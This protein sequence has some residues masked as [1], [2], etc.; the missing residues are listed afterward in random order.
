MANTSK[1]ELNPIKIY[2]NYSKH[3]EFR[4]K[5]HRIGGVYGFIHIV[6]GTPKN[7]Y[8]GSSKDLYQRFLDQFKGRDSNSR[9]QRAINKYGI[10]N[11]NFVVY[12]ID[13][14]PNVSWLI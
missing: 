1:N 3:G 6:E 11:F 4:E 12:Y 13:E 14:Y 10:E 9:L 2:K 7:K 5:L 8:K